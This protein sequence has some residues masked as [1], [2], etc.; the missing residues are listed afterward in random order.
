MHMPAMNVP[1]STAIDT[2]D[3]PSTSCRPWNQMIS[4]ISAAQPLPRNISRTIGKKRSV[5]VSGAAAA[6][7]AVGPAAR[8]PARLRLAA[9]IASATMI[10]ASVTSNGPSGLR[11]GAAVCGGRQL[12]RRLRP[13]RHR[14]LDRLQRRRK[15]R[16]RAAVGG[17][18]RDRKRAVAVALADAQVADRGRLDLHRAR[19]H[20]VAAV[21]QVRRLHQQVERLPV[22]RARHLVGVVGVR[23]QEEGA[24]RR[25]LA[26][27]VADRSGRAL[28][29]DRRR[30]VPHRALRHR[31]AVGDQ[32]RAAGHVALLPRRLA[33]EQVVGGAVRRRRCGTRRPA[34]KL[35]GKREAC[36]RQTTEECDEGESGPRLKRAKGS[37]LPRILET[38]MILGRRDEDELQTHAGLR[39][40]CALALLALPACSDGRAAD[41]ARS[42]SCTGGMRAGRARR[43]A[44]CSAC[45]RRQNPAMRDRRLQRRRRQQ[46][47]SARRSRT[48]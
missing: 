41:T 29:L 31:V 44:R 40:R 21:D 45:S 19:A 2:A 16:R 18:L 36:A 5:L 11:A 13:D 37:S 22:G 39:L 34:R 20:A 27:V 6:A 12:A 23:L 42:R 24:H 48:G 35:H 7:V 8:A 15:R 30:S 3:D 32:R 47:G 26:E 9:T 28:Q 17:E 10:R 33:R 43:S 46:R 25:R 38:D 1:S 4:Y 14:R